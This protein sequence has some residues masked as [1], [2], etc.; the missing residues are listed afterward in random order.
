MGDKVDHLSQTL[1]RN[2]R[3]GQPSA[4]SSTSHVRRSSDAGSSSSPLPT[5]V[6]SKDASRRLPQPR[7]ETRTKGSAA[8]TALQP[9]PSQPQ[10]VPPH[11]CEQQICSM[12]TVFETTELLEMILTFLEARDVVPL[13]RTCKKW[14]S[15]IRQSP[16]L[17]ANLFIF[18]QW[19]RDPSDFQL[20]NLKIPGLQ[21]DLGEPVD[22]GRWIQISMSVSAARSIVGSTTRRPRSRS[23]SSFIRG[24]LGSRLQ[25]A[26]S[27]RAVT[28]SAPALNWNLQQEKLLVLQPP[29][30][31]MQAFIQSQGDREDDD[32]ESIP[33]ACAKLACDAG[34]TLGFLAETA[35]SLLADGKTT[36]DP[37]ASRTV[38]FKAIVSFCAP[39]VALRKRSLVRTVT[40]IG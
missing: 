34:V 12:A 4:S 6:Q 19:N 3:V 17:R 21:F 9:A 37:D 32:D 38:I 33:C 26:S 29:I 30:V 13:Q 14:T 31:G 36:D 39:V 23:M 16:Q 15:L 10:P 7:E 35:L 20:L 40:S 24:G 28:E 11:E 27:S 8:P 18:P 2:L 1:S 25:I 5:V 22:L